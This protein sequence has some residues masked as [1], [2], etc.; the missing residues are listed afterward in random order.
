M[1][2]KD[3]ATR[4]ARLGALRGMARDYAGKRLER[5]RLTI[6]IGEAEMEPEV[7]IGEA[8]MEEEEED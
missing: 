5:P 7:E 4:A 2:Q 6:T 3:K 1:A 8:V